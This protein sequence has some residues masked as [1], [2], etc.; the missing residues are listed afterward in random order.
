MPGQILVAGMHRSGTSIV[1]R[2]LTFMGVGFGPEELST[3]VRVVVARTST[4]CSHWF[5]K[6]S[7]RRTACARAPCLAFNRM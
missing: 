4:V 5:C 1:T 6:L 2:L 3:R 7:S